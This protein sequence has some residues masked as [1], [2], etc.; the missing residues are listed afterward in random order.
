MK[1]LNA[2]I[3]MV[4][5]LTTLA[6]LSVSASIDEVWQCTLNEDKK[7]EEVRAANDVWLKFVNSKVK[8]GGITSASVVPVVGDQGSFMFVDNFPSMQSWIDTKALMKTE[9]GQKIEEALLESATCTRN[10]LFE[11]TLQTVK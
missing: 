9:A 7:M 2:A 8:G 5:V 10:R 3:G 11:K 6:S 4:A 1:T